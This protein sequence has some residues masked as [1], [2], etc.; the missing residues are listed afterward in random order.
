MTGFAH[1]VRPKIAHAAC[2]VD[3]IDKGGCGVS[4]IDAP[5]PRLVID[6]DKTGAPL[7]KSQTKC[8]FL[9]FADPDLVIAIEIKAGAPN[10]AQARKQLQA[11]ANAAEGLAPR[12][13]RV[14]FQPVLASKSLRRDKQIELRQATVEFRKRREKIRR[15]ACGAPLTDALGAP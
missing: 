7:G 9:L 5:R 4:L 13:L 3:R 2:L 12:D 11:G 1:S 14:T 6:L 15:V 8:D 10:I